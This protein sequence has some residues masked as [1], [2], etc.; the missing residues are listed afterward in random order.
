MF[1]VLITIQ[2]ESVLLSVI[3]LYKHQQEP[4]VIFILVV[5]LLLSLEVTD[6]H[7]NR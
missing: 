3:V 4:F 1:S 5:L 2:Y 7:M 6:C